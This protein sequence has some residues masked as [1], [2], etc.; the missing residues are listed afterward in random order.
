MNTIKIPSDW[1]PPKYNFGQMVRQGEIVG[2][3]NH[4]DAG[5]HYWVR[6]DANSEDTQSYPEFQINPFS[7]EE[8]RAL[9][10]SEIQFHQSKITAL[11]EQLK[12]VEE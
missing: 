2:M 11:V 8:L 7:P 4:F 6:P 5:W 12:R 10:H 1:T 9:L 3:E